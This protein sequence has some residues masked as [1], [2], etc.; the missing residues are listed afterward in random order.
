MHKLQLNVPQGPLELQLTVIRLGNR[1]AFVLV[2]TSQKLF[3][4]HWELISARSNYF[5][6]ALSAPFKESQKGVVHLPDQDPDTFELYMK[7]LYW[8]KLYSGDGEDY[9][10]EFQRLA[11]VGILADY[12]QDHGCFNLVVDAII[13]VAETVEQY[14]LTLATAVYEQ[15]PTDSPLRRLIR[16]FW[17]WVHNPQWYSVVDLMDCD[18]D[19]ISA[20]KDFWIDVSKEMAEVGAKSFNQSVKT[21]WVKN[22]CSYHVHPDGKSCNGV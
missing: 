2:G 1:V 22:R 16:D 9:D 20:P 11:A 10:A 21:P 6:K 19:V 5:E 17:V 15:L 12:L 13:D 8:G 18:Y 3:T 4:I 14:P 7:S